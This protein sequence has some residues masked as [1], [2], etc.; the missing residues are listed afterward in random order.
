MKIFRKQCI[1]KYS[2]LE[3]RLR[4][5]GQVTETIDRIFRSGQSKRV[6]YPWVEFKDFEMSPKSMI[7]LN[8]EFQVASEH[9]C[10][11]KNPLW[12]ASTRDRVGEEHHGVFAKCKILQGEMIL[13][14]RPIWTD[15]ETRNG[16]KLC[17]ASYYYIS[18]S[19]TIQP[20]YCMPRFCSESC[21]QQADDT[22]HNIIC[23]KDFSWLQKAPRE[24][25]QT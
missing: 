17:P 25:E 24:V 4:V 2:R 9:T 11:K 13:I 19:L 20:T 7:K 8:A 23:G 16:D 14:T 10:I 5:Q 3:D 6:A 21:M 1:E 15:E 22:Y 18:E 12:G